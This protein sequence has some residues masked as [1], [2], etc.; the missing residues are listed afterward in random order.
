MFCSMNDVHKSFHYRGF[1]IAMCCNEALSHSRTRPGGTAPNTMSEQE[2]LHQATN[3][4]LSDTVPTQEEYDILNGPEGCLDQYASSRNAINL[5]QLIKDGKHLDWIEGESDGR[6]VLI[7]CIKDSDDQIFKHPVLD[8]QYSGASNSMLVMFPF[9]Q[10]QK[11]AMSPGEI[12]ASKARLEGVPVETV[13]LDEKARQEIAIRGAPS[14]DGGVGSIK[15]LELIYNELKEL[16][17]IRAAIALIN[18]KHPD[19]KQFKGSAQELADAI[20]NKHDSRIYAMIKPPRETTDDNGNTIVTKDAPLRSNMF[21][22]RKHSERNMDPTRTAPVEFN[23]LSPEDK[24]S[25]INVLKRAQGNRVFMPMKITLDDGKPGSSTMLNN[26]FIGAIVARLGHLTFGGIGQRG[27]FIRM[28]DEAIVF[29]NGPPRSSETQSFDATSF[30][31]NM[32]QKKRRNEESD[33]IK[34]QSAS[35]KRAKTATSFEDVKRKLARK[36]SMK[37]SPRA[38]NDSE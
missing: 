27:V 3:H 11:Y 7:T 29:R 8:R 1:A 30:V 28:A 15:D 35:E 37:R 22:F 32:I 36:K 6:A 9:A 25:V 34:D 10:I 4:A 2:D 38:E 16:Y 17:S 13:E 20:M 14:S 26:R 12:R 23:A 31:A 24:E 21:P 19:F 5:L 33:P 18:S